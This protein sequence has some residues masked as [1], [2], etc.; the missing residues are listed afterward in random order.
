[1]KNKLDNRFK[2][3]SG[4]YYILKDNFLC[5]DT[6][7]WPE[8]FCVVSTLRDLELLVVE[9]YN[10]SSARQKVNN[11]L[12]LQGESG[13]GSLPF[14]ICRGFYR[15]ITKDKYQEY[16]YNGSARL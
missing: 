9:Y 14:R 8:V 11:K 12:L 1:M 13:R 6:I 4:D 5:D 2:P 15:K 10:H 16:K 3:Q 7:Q